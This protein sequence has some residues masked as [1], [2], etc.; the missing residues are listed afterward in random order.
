MLWDPVPSISSFRGKQELAAGPG[1]LL[2]KKGKT[3]SNPDILPRPSNF[4]AGSSIPHLA[5]SQEPGQSLSTA[6]LGSL[7]KAEAWLQPSTTTWRL[8]LKNIYLF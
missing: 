6:T 7:R 2:R 3:V 8:F 5:P 1:Y 4:S